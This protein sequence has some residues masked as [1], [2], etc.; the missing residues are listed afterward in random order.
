MIR[1]IYTRHTSWR[2]KLRRYLSVHLSRN[3][4]QII[5]R[6]I[7]SRISY[8]F[9]SKLKRNPFEAWKLEGI[10]VFDEDFAFLLVKM[11]DQITG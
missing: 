10:F 9:F 4:C 1:Q 6:A 2:A 7:D 11:G 8:K 5:F 3:L